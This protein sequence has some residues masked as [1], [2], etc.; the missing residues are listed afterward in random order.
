MYLAISKLAFNSVVL[1]S[2]SSL[3]YL[4]VLVSVVFIIL[5][6]MAVIKNYRLKADNERLSKLNPFDEM[7]D[8]YKDFTHGHMYNTENKN[9]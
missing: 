4:L 8:K 5:I 6:A 7:D 3:T 9:D 2:T 1:I